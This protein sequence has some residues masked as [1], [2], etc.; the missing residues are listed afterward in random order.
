MVN[1]KL[2]LVL[3]VID[4]LDLKI[5]CFGCVVVINLNFIKVIK[6]VD[7]L[8]VDS[9]ILVDGNGLCCGNGNCLFD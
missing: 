6:D 5:D 8:I 2:V 1:D 9:E 4:M 3:K 7:V